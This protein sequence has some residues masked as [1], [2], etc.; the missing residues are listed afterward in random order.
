[1]PLIHV[2]MSPETQ[3]PETVEYIRSGE[4][5]RDQETLANALNAP[6]T[7]LSS[8][9]L[10]ATGR[11]QDPSQNQVISYDTEYANKIVETNK[12]TLIWNS[13]GTFHRR[14]FGNPG[15]AQL[16]EEQPEGLSRKWQS[17]FGARDET[18]MKGFKPLADGKT[19][20]VVMTTVG[21]WGGFLNGVEN[22]LGN[23]SNTR[24]AFSVKRILLETGELQ[25]TIAISAPRALPYRSDVARSVVDISHNNTR[26]ATV[27]DQQ[28]RIVSLEQKNWRGYAKELSKINIDAPA[29]SVEALS[30][31]PNDNMLLVKTDDG[32]RFVDIAQGVQLRI[33]LTSESGTPEIESKSTPKTLVAANQVIFSN[34]SKSLIITD[35]QNGIVCYDYHRDGKTLVLSEQWNIPIGEES[36]PK[37]ADLNDNEDRLVVTTR[38]G[39]A[40][41]SFQNGLKELPRMTQEFDCAG[42]QPQALAFSSDGRVLLSTSIYSRVPSADP[43]MRG[44]MQ[45]NQFHIVDRH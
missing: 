14:T 41:Y 2:N 33:R 15:Q 38:R 9:T 23:K 13:N 10:P 29:S 17:N 12:G 34:N 18:T 44:S 37:L 28:V 43:T 22:L 20:L 24:Q 19:G 39:I 45:G 21:Y 30:F 4:R 31:S 3:D 7:K 32:A 8:H 16:L 6:I 25:D 5:D 27:V 26:L 11:A 42:K 40:I 35:S 1:M 36:N